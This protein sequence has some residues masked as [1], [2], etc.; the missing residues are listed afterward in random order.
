MDTGRDG[1]QDDDSRTRRHQRE[2]RTVSS[3]KVGLIG[4]DGI[5]PEVVAE[6]LKVV[7]RRRRVRWPPPS[8]TWGRPLRPHRRGPPRPG[9]R[10]AARQQDAIL[11]GAVG[12]PV[13][14]DAVPPGP[15]SGGCSSASDSSSTSTST[16]ARSPGCPARWRPTATSWSSARTPRGP[17][18]ARAASSAGAPPSRWPPRDRSTPATA[19]S[20]APG[21][22]SPWPSGRPRHHLTLVHK[23]NVLTFAGDLWQRTVNEFSTDY[24]AGHP[25]LQPRRRHLHLPGRERLP[26]RRD[27]HRQPVRRHHHRPGRRHRRG[28][29]LCGVGQPQPGPHRTL[30]VRAGARGRP[31]HRRHRKG[32]SGR[33]HPLGRPDARPPRRVARP[34][35]R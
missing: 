18:P 22:P 35:T 20:G 28:H 30:A 11:L 10:G 17:T 14:S 4:G 9:A 25:R 15:S 3:Y 32:Q 13:G 16:C 31:R 21:S 34:P 12:P 6:A 24:P 7:E 5:G 1:R 29:R 2:L 27:R 19:W 23:T 8:T 33:R 26:L